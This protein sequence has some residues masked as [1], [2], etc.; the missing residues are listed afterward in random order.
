MKRIASWFLVLGLLGPLA[1][2]TG[3][4]AWADPIQPTFTSQRR[5]TVPLPYAPQV[6][7]PTATASL[8]GSVQ[9]TA[10]ADGQNAPPAMANQPKLTLTGN[11]QNPN[12][13]P[14]NVQAMTTTAMSPNTPGTTAQSS[15]L[16]SVQAQRA[17]TA[18]QVEIVSTQNLALTLNLG[19]PAVGAGITVASATARSRDPIS[20]GTDGFG[21][22][23]LD[24]GDMVVMDFDLLGG[25]AP[26]GTMYTTQG[27]VLPDAAVENPDDLFDD[28]DD[29]S[30]MFA[31]SASLAALGLQSLAAGVEPI[32]TLTI[33]NTGPVLTIV[34]IAGTSNNFLFTFS[35]TAQEIQNNVRDLLAGGNFPVLTITTTLQRDMAN[36]TFGNEDLLEATVTSVP[37]PASVVLGLLGGTCLT[38]ALR[39]RKRR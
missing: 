30:T 21:D 9:A 37:E 32:F 31:Q 23:G 28:S 16:I 13:I 39:Q 15:A 12:F 36:A 8:F 25:S 38:L 33:D 19:T 34:F 4:P 22:M 18:P 24:A 14:N 1:G 29:M 7:S 26:A 27:V 35:R 20:L 6:D 11:V 5:L 10:T 2:L 17:A 3:G